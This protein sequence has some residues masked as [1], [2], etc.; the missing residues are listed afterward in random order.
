MGRP[1]GSEIRERVALILSQMGPSHGYGI[2][3]IYKKNWGPVEIKSIYYNL[4]K[5]VD[6]GH[7]ELL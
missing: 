6:I 7:F 1:I 5:G 3:K 2:Y 4:Q